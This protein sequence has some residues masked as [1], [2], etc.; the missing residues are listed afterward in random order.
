MKTLVL[1]LNGTLCFQEYKLGA[2][3]EFYKRPGL[4]VFLQRLS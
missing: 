2:G 1:N 3:V 4:S